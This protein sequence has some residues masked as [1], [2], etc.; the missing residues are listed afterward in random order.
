MIGDLVVELVAPDGTAYPLHDR[1]GSSADDIHTT[2]TVDAS[3][4]A[5]SGTWLLRV[6][7]LAAQDVGYVDGWSL[8]F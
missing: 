1:T 2:Y 4:E 5:A 3:P 6:K 7:D 8:T